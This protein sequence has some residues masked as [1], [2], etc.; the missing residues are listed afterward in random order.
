MLSTGVMSCVPCASHVTQG[1]SLNV[2]EVPF[3]PENG[4]APPS[5][6][7]WVAL[8]MRQSEVLKSMEDCL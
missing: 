5:S 8:R 2:T 6:L 1:K 4:S 3:C 7:G